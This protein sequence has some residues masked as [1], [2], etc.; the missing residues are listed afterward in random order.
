[1]PKTK[2]EIV[3]S[4]KRTLEAFTGHKVEITLKSKGDTLLEK[5][6]CNEIL[7]VVE[8]FNKEGIAITAHSTTKAIA[9]LRR[10]FF[11]LATKGGYKN[12]LILRVMTKDG[13]VYDHKCI[14][15]HLKKGRDLYET[16]LRFKKLYDNIQSA[17]TSTYAARL[18]D[19]ERAA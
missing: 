2:D 18:S 6:S 5:I 19:R 15:Y 17:I 13:T 8:Q 9:D 14:S 1:M 4:H 11:M 7:K 3:Q 10:V 16:D 12:A